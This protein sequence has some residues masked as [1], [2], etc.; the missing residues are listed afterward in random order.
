MPAP[1][2]PL[3]VAHETILILILSYKHDVGVGKAVLCAS[4]ATCTVLGTQSEKVNYI[5]PDS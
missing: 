1:R 2:F 4:R 5:M 3:M